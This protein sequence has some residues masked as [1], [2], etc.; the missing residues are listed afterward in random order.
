MKEWFVLV[1][2][3]IENR[4]WGNSS[5][6]IVKSD[7]TLCE[8]EVGK[9]AIEIGKK[10]DRENGNGFFIPRVQIL[11]STTSPSLTM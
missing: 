2:R 4:N 3:Q 5:I 9:L 8:D 11:I 10:R 7:E 1:T 6:E